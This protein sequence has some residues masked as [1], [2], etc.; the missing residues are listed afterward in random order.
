MISDA[1]SFS[2]FDDGPVSDALHPSAEEVEVSSSF[3]DY[4]IG[5]HI[6]VCYW[7]KFVGPLVAGVPVTLGL[8]SHL[9]IEWLSSEDLRENNSW[10]SSYFDLGQPGFDGGVVQIAFVVFVHQ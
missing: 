10:G 9:G 2:V 8:T 6:W 5:V 4:P 1:H 7:N 3:R